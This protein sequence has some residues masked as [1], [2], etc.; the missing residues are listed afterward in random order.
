MAPITF[1][2]SKII[3]YGPQPCENCAVPIVKMA[4]E[5][6]GTAFTSPEGPIY[7]NSEWH[8]HV[9][10]PMFVQRHARQSH[11]ELLERY[12]DARA[13]HTAEQGWVIVSGSSNLNLACDWPRNQ[14][15]PYMDTEAEAWIAARDIAYST[16]AAQPEKP[17]SF[18]EP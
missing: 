3:Y 6:G 9:C 18:I 4:R 11:Q 14:S 2:N 7:P 12:P 8:P 15:C 5:F 10:D 16:C 1:R 17:R 13:C